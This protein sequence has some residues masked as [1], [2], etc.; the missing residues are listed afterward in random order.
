MSS[1]TL[2]YCFGSWAGIGMMKRFS[3]VHIRNSSKPQPCN[4]NYSRQ[5]NIM[6]LRSIGS[7]QKSSSQVLLPSKLL[8]WSPSADK[9][10][11]SLSQGF[12]FFSFLPAHQ[13]WLKIW[14]IKIYMETLFIMHLMFGTTLT[15]TWKL[16]EVFV[17]IHSRLRT[18]TTFLS[19]EGWHKGDL[20]SN[21]IEKR[22]ADLEN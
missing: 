7:V 22:E 10:S 6:I 5:Y 1:Q 2:L 19:G 4:K 13:F 16:Q 3:R 18:N 15:V 14:F 11:A 20:V 21:M 8:T 17:L 12:F 9:F